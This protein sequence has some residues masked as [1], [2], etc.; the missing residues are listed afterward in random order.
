M[1]Q[2]KER[3]RVDI[4]QMYALAIDGVVPCLAGWLAG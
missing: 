2:E 4:G 1:E 3:D